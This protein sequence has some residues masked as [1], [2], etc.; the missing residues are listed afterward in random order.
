MKEGIQRRSKTMGT[1]SIDVRT[2]DTGERRVLLGGSS[3]AS[4]SSRK[5]SES[6]ESRGAG[7]FEDHLRSAMRQTSAKDHE[8]SGARF[9]EE[10]AESLTPAFNYRKGKRSDK[11]SARCK[12][13]VT[14][15]I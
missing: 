2:V 1:V 14:F 4:G 6:D 5:R 3:H 9:Q 12:R 13:R 15:A 10:I 7:K 11:K 8:T